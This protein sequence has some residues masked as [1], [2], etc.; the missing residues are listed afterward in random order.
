MV[1]GNISFFKK[2]NFRLKIHLKINL[3][4]AS[5]SGGGGGG[6]LCTI[7]LLEGGRI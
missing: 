2:R 7:L 6:G 3:K 4:F 5:L 1:A